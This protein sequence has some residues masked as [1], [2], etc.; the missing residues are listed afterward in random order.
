MNLDVERLAAHFAQQPVLPCLVQGDEALLVLEAADAYGEAARRQGFVER[1]AYTVEGRFHW[2][3]VLADLN[4]G[5][6]F[7]AQKLLE[8]RLTSNKPS[9]E[10]QQGLS[11][12]WARLNPDIALLVTAP[13]L[14]RQALSA[15]W[16]QAFATQGVIVSA[17]V[18]DREALP[19]FL[20]RRLAAQ[21]QTPGAG[22]LEFLAPRVEGNLLAAKQELQKLALLCPAGELS[23]AQVESAVR[24]VARFD[25]FQL[26]EALLTADAGRFVRILDGLAAEG[27]SPTL[28]LWVV[29]E[30]LHAVLAVMAAQQQGRSLQ[31]LKQ[32]YRLWGDRERW[33]LAAA[34][35]WPAA[36][37]WAAVRRCAALDR[38]AKGVGADDPW[39]GLQQLM[40]ALAM[41]ARATGR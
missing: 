38:A 31:V 24:D 5:S 22:V 16:A 7:A 33:V 29:A 36:Q 4:A 25:A 15:P 35:R 1:T 3:E 30:D 6:L 8:I 39:R 28:A 27:E 2:Q 26:S 20:R 18:V 34:R 41:P 10:A 37:L 11:E 21:Q 13:R 23:L 9:A 40:L 14:D 12:V 32:M 19:G 17:P